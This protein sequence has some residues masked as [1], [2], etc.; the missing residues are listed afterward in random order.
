MHE[1]GIVRDLVRRL[2]QAAREAGAE[3]VS[4]VSVWLGALS[5]FSP[6]HFREHFDDEARGTI[7]EGASLDIE[8]SD[9]PT[10]PDAQ[11]VMLRSVDLEVADER[12]D[13]S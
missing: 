8:T 12:S 6:G 4:G 11:N 5:H 1:T 13:T 7:A 2:E 3:R 9:D 10:H